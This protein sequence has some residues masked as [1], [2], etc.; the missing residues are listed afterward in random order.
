MTGISVVLRLF[1]QLNS[2]HSLH[3][4]Y[5]GFAQKENLKVRARTSLY[6]LI[7]VASTCGA[8]VHQRA[9]KEPIPEYR[10]SLQQRANRSRCRRHKY[11]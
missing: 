6:R 2:L 8:R 9:S 10:R 7:F 11:G 3:L 4:R 1:S 5:G